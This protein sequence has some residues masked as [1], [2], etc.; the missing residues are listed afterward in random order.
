MILQQSVI[1]S[2]IDNASN[3]KAWI[4]IIPPARVVTMAEKTAQGKKTNIADTARIKFLL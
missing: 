2:T 4:S 3:Q 1:V